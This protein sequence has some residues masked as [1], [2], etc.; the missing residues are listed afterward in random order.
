MVE[1]RLAR[2]MVFVLLMFG[3]VSVACSDEAEETWERMVFHIDETINARWALM[4]ANAYLDDS[5]RAKIVIVA[6]GP[7]IDFLLEGAEDARGNPY[8][9]A[10]MELAGKGVA[11]RVCAATLDARQ[12][13]RNRIVEDAIIVPSG[14]SE[15]ARL[16]I[17][18][19]F[20]Y[21]KP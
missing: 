13:S 15:I 8:A 3:L 12:I 18:E 4:L 16:Q 14:L 10:V 6:F 17:K 1:P 2:R 11:F 20:A 5:P 9:V 19:G 7:G 21:L